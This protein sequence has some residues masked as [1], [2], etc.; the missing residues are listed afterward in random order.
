[1]ATIYISGLS[2]KTIGSQLEGLFQVH[3]I[4]VNK[5]KIPCY[6]KGPSRGQPLGIAFVDIDDRYVEATLRL[7][8]IKCDGMSLKISFALNQKP[9]IKAA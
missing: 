6:Q 4:F 5:I 1:M 8:G 3:G 7:N 9:P 2:K